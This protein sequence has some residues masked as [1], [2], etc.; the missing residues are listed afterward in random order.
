VIP[1][2]DAH[3]ADLNNPHGTTKAQVGLSAVQNFGIATQAEAEAGT[4]A[5]KYMT[6]LQTK[7]AIAV[8]ATSGLTA[9]LADV[10]NPHAT[11]KAQVGLGSVENLPLASIAEAEAASRNDRYMTPLMTAKQ[12]QVLVKDSVDLHLNATNNPHLVTKAQVG[13]SNVAN[14]LIATEAEA[15]AGLVNTSYMTPLMT[16][17][18][19]EAIATGSI[20]AHLADNNNPHATTKAQV[21][22]GSVENYS[23]ANTTEAQ[24]GESN[25]RYMTPLLV[26][27]AIDAQ[28]G[29]GITSHVS[30]INNPHQVTASQVGTYSSSVLDGKFNVKLDKL[31]QA[32]DSALLGG[33]SYDDVLASAKS[34]GTVNSDKLENQTLSQILNTA[35]TTTV[36]NAAKLGGKTAAEIGVDLVATLPYTKQLA[37]PAQ[38]YTIDGSYK[39]IP[40]CMASP[41]MEVDLEDFVVEF[42]GMRESNGQAVTGLITFNPTNLIGSVTILSANET[43]LDIVYTNVGGVLRFWLKTN[44][45]FAATTLT[46]ISGKAWITIEADADLSTTAPI[47]SVVVPV[48]GLTTTAETQALLTQL[49][50]SFDTLNTAL[51]ALG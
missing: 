14:Y 49:K 17:K 30:N 25:I 31:A 9:H 23:I 7:Q 4:V 16:R 12:I 13:L 21:G 41:V 37:V 29:G 8:L 3:K 2:L 40:L 32:T 6:P 28:V 24:L 10:N 39:W 34:Q 15:T 47:G 48:A 44:V 33:H 18:A 5:N 20:G 38:E 42:T 26:K 43:N 51:V 11:T 45:E 35:K 1:L 22:L 19:I 50:T 36:D 46:V 27:A